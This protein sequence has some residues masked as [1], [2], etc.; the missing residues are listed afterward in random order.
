MRLFSLYFNVPE[1]QCEN[2]YDDEK[3]LECKTNVTYSRALQDK[4]VVLLQNQRRFQ[5]DLYSGESPIIE[6]S[7]LSW[8]TF[9]DTNQLEAFQ[10]REQELSRDDNLAFALHGLT[11]N[12]DKAFQVKSYER[13]DN[14]YDYYSR[15]MIKWHM[16]KDVDSVER[17]VYNFFMLLGDVGGL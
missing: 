3:D 9:S 7:Y 10:I 12:E 13:K 5:A 14:S 2:K 6:E 17:S 4:Y 1:E 11:D 16:Q 15:L 8:V